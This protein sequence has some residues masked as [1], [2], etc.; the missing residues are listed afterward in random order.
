MFSSFTNYYAKK[1]INKTNLFQFAQMC[2]PVCMGTNL[3]L[4]Y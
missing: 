2:Y 3:I 4:L 1:V